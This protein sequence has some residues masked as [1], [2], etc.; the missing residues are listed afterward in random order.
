MRMTTMRTIYSRLLVSALVIATM[1]A[2][3][4]RANT[5]ASAVPLAHAPIAAHR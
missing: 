4:L 2:F 3:G 5:P 1:L